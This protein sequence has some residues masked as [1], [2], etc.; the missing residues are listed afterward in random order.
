MQRQEEGNST[1]QK[2]RGKETERK[3]P[4]IIFDFFLA[5][6]HRDAECGW[7]QHPVKDVH[8]EKFSLFLAIHAPRRGIV[9]L[10][11]VKNG[12]RVAL[13]KV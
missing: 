8:T 11:Q 7:V 2:D 9:E 13:L 6:K 5:A 3:F 10:W 1:N 4:V 12:P